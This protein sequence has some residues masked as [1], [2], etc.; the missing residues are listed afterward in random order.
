MAA[1]LM[2]RCASKT[3]RSIFSKISRNSLFRLSTKPTDGDTASGSNVEDHKGD[4][5]TQTASSGERALAGFAKALEKARMEARAVPEHD[6]ADDIQEKTETEHATFAAM[7]RHSKLMQLG[8]YAGRMVVGTIFEVVGD[9]L[10]IDIG[11]KFHCVCPRP[12]LNAER[13]HRGVKVKLRLN[14]P[15]MSS[16]FLGSEK[17]VT[18]LEADATLIGLRRQP[19]SLSSSSPQSSPSS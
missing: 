17:H 12:K 1:S 11:G 3:S 19:A 10:Y 14:D 7:L 13:Y 6:E 9:D 18:L 5:A 15:E 16:S 8:D 4:A 2:T